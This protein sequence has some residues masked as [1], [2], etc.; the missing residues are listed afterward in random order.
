MR[1]STASSAFRLACVAAV[2]LS[3]AIVRAHGGHEGVAPAIQAITIGSEPWQIGFAVVPPDPIAGENLHIELKAEPLHQAAG[4]VRRLTADEVRVRIGDEV[5]PLRRTEIKGVLGGE[6]RADAAGDHV[7]TVE[8]TGPAR[9]TAEFPLL[10]RAGS[11]SRIRRALI[12]LF[13]VLLVGAGALVAWNASLRAALIGAEYRGRVVAAVVLLAV[14]I[15]L[16][17]G[18]GSTIVARNFVPPREE[19][20]VD[21]VPDTPP[22]EPLQSAASGETSGDVAATAEATPH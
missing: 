1:R 12:T 5:V 10:V 11:L 6:Y 3:C 14:V 15:G 19:Q 7:V 2:G 9:A 20:S 8:V 21:W 18:P 22:G 13:A 16:A 17:I 4:Q